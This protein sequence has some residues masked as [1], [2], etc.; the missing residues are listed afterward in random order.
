MFTIITVTI[1]PAKFWNILNTANPEKEIAEDHKKI[2]L[3]GNLSEIIP[4]ITIDIIPV[5]EP[6]KNTIPILS[7]PT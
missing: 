1:N 3:N 6:K 7:Y 2:F 5:S 4:A